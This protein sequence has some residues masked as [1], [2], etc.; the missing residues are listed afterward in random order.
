MKTYFLSISMLFCLLTS[1]KQENKETAN[2]ETVTQS[3]EQTDVTT[4]TKNT[5]KLAIDLE[6]L[7]PIE[8]LD[9]HN[10]N[11]YEKYGIE[12]SGNCYACDLASLSITNN[13]IIWTNVCDEEDTFEITDFSFT[14]EGNQTILKTT[15]RTLLLTQIDKV[16]VY[17]LVIEGKKLE[18]DNKR[19]AKYFTTKAALPNFKEHDCGDFDG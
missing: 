19:I 10:T 12:F 15:D 2:Q 17:E 14:T 18:M 11:V 6:T 13:H 3:I 7:V 8:I 4:T 16:P 1:C 5:S 9:E